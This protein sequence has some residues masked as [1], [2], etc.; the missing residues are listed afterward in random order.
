MEQQ[1]ETSHL[2][3]AWGGVRGVG[4]G[5]MVGKGVGGAVPN[6][7]VV[8]HLVST[9][10]CTDSLFPYPSWVM[11]ASWGPQLRLL[12][13]TCL[14]VQLYLG[15]ESPHGPLRVKPCCAGTETGD[16]ASPQGRSEEV[17]EGA[18]R[19]DVNLYQDEN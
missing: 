5:E 3:K 19:G 11:P 8:P 6:S 2:P 14:L 13:P 16:G 9:G 15:T 12:L 1:A 18:V 7:G 4:G 17:W 10:G